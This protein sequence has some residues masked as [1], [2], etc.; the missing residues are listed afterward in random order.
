[1]TPA[2]ILS[3]ARPSTSRLALVSVKRIHRRLRWPLVWR[4]VPA[5]STSQSNSSISATQPVNPRPRRSTTHWPDRRPSA[6]R[7]RARPSRSA[8]R[9]VNSRASRTFHAQVCR[10]NRWAI[11]NRSRRDP[12][13]RCSPMSARRVTTRWPELW[14][15]VLKTKCH[16]SDALNRISRRFQNRDFNAINDTRRGRDARCCAAPWSNADFV[17]ESI[18]TCEHVFHFHTRSDPHR[19][20]V[21]PTAVNAATSSIARTASSI[22]AAGRPVSKNQSMRPRD[23][24]LKCGGC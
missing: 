20:H 1:V 7:S 4:S 16:L 14:C 2:N 21:P 24:R 5:A 17:A 3:I 13:I 11:A 6:R 15:S 10:T 12:R 23:A 9:W 8:S 22:A 18:S 19:D